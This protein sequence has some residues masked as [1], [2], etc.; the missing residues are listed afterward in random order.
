MHANIISALPL[1]FLILQLQHHICLLGQLFAV[2]N[3]DDAFV[4][5]VGGPAQDIDD[6]GGGGFV[7]VAG[8]LVRQYD[9]C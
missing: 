3:D 7:Q 5:F 1:Q 2:G 4:V 6:I 9:R 8:W